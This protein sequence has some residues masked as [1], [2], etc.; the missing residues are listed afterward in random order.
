MT[1]LSRSV[2]PVTVKTLILLLLAFAQTVIVLAQQYDDSAYR[3]YHAES[4]EEA[5]LKAQLKKEQA[6][7]E[8]ARRAQLDAENTQLN[9]LH[10]G[11]AFYAGLPV[12]QKYFDAN[13]YQ[14]GSREYAEAIRVPGCP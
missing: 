1:G 7:L 12:L 10:Q 8:L 5:L 2:Y 9:T 4:Q 3:P 6:E 13:G 14:P 11:A